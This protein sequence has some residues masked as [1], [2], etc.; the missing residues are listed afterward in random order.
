[1]KN[2]LR[3]Y[4]L[5]RIAFLKENESLTYARLKQSG[6]LI[7]EAIRAQD[8]AADLFGEMIEQGAPVAAANECARALLYKPLSPQPTLE[9][10]RLQRENQ[11]EAMNLFL[12]QPTPEPQANPPEPRRLR[13]VTM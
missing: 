12:N 1:M 6:E 2:Q 7:S 11:V 4:S 5:E 9:E 10:K 8:A 13:L 3:Q